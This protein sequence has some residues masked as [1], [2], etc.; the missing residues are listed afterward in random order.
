MSASRP[1]CPLSPDEAAF[2]RELVGS[3]RTFRELAADC[4][5][6]WDVPAWR[7]DQLVGI[8]LVVTAGM[9]SALAT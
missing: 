4:A 2:V 5:D 3:G 8:E 7:G 6:A 9:E 1:T